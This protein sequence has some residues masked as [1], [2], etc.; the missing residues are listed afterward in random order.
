VPIHDIAIHQ[1]EN[2]IILGTHGRSLYIA[3]LKEVQRLLGDEKYRKEKE[4]DARKR[5]MGTV[6]CPP[7]CD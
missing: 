7:N 1:R 6:P 3:K 4:E 2:E 5:L